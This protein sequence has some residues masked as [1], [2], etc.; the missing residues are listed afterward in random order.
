M[1]AV[2]L[3]HRPGGLDRRRAADTGVEDCRVE[4]VEVLDGQPHRLD[5]RLL[6]GDVTLE[7]H[8]VLDGV[9]LGEAGRVGV[10]GNDPVAPFGEQLHGCPADPGGG[11][12][13]DD[14]RKCHAF[15]FY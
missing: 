2:E 11:A 9:E 10:H 14:C 13:H 12:G 3:L 6:G 4:A 7:R 1:D 15:P 8:D 5:V